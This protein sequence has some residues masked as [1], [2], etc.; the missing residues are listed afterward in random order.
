MP[1][2]LKYRQSGQALSRLAA[3]TRSLSAGFVDLL[4]PPHCANCGDEVDVPPG[5]ALLCPPCRQDFSSQAETPR[6]VRCGMML[7]PAMADRCPHCLGQRLHFDRVFA[8][9]AYD[10]QLRRALL[11]LKKPGHDMLADAL[12]SL[13]WRKHNSQITQIPLD[14]VV[15]VPLHWARRLARGNNSAEI[16]AEC[17]GRR[18]KVYVESRLLIRRR[19]TSPHSGLTHRQR[20]INIRGALSVRKGYDLG[21]AHILLV[22]DILTTGATCNEAARVLKAAGAAWVGVAIIAR[23]DAPN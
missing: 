12:A 7:A 1:I 14:A 8:W 15:P 9:G 5:E 10:D 6:C 23:A 19:N 20:R 21:A 11:C 16:L 13:F 3:A 18:V 2:R 4:A 22:D 17:L